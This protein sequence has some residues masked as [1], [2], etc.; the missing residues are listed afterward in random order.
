MTVYKVKGL[1]F[2]KFLQKARASSLEIK[3]LQKISHDE[4][5]IAVGE[6]HLKTFLSIAAQMNYKVR[7]ISISPYR[8][9][10][11]FV[12]SNVAFVLCAAIILSILPFAML[13][14]SKTEIY[15]LKTTSKQEVLE[16]LAQ[17]GYKEGKLKSEYDLPSLEKVLVRSLPNI[18]LASAVIKG[19]TLIVNLHEMI[20]NSAV[21]YNYQP[22]L[23][24][25]DC[26][27][28]SIDLVSGTSQKRPGDTVK[29]G[30]IVISPSAQLN[31]GGTLS[32]PAKGEVVA[33]F[34]L[35]QTFFVSIGLSQEY[36]QKLFGKNKNML[37]NIMSNME[38]LDS[39]QETTQKVDAL[40]GTYYTICLSGRVKF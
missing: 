39:P 35:S 12:K 17:N 28:E 7:E 29:K 1:N 21:L 9:F 14:V 3:T 19:N 10:L 27:I 4:F 37:Y 13:F 31:S 26:I 16:V 11:R 8:R 40:D 33:S 2:D 15:G 20:D 18:S 24:P 22:I 23:A 38:I 36:Q 34:E 30:E 5:Q 25:V 6:R 32:I